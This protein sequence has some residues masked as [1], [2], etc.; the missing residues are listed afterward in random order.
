[1]RK[2]EV[3]AL[4]TALVLVVVSGGAHA[5]VRSGMY[6]ASTPAGPNWP[7]LEKPAWE[8]QNRNGIE[9]FR[10]GEL[11]GPTG[12]QRLSWRVIL[13]GEP[14]D[15][16]A[17]VRIP[18]SADN[19]VTSLLWEGCMVTFTKL[20]YSPADRYPQFYIRMAAGTLRI[21]YNNDTTGGG[22]RGWY[23]Y[24]SPS[25]G[26]RTGGGVIL[27]GTTYG[28]PVDH[29][30][31]HTLR[32]TTYTDGTW[33]VWLND[34]S[35]AANELWG[36][37][38]PVQSTKMIRWGVPDG[39]NRTVRFV[40]RA[41]YWGQGE[42]E[43]DPIPGPSETY[44]IGGVSVSASG[45]SATVTWTTEPGKNMVVNKVYYGDKFHTI[46]KA[47]DAV[48][49]TDHWEAQLNDLDWN[50]AYTFYC[51]ST[52]DTG[53][54][55][56]TPLHTFR[57]DSIVL[58][59]IANPG[60]EAGTDIY[61]WV[62]VFAPGPGEDDTQR[63][64]RV[65][66]DID[67]IMAGSNPGALLPAS[68]NPNIGEPA[69]FSGFKTGGSPFR[70]YGTI[71]Q[72][73]AVDVDKW[74]K[75]QVK[76]Q[77]WGN[78][79]YKPNDMIGRVGLD[80]NGDD[81]PGTL[82]GGV[83]TS[84][85]DVWWGQ[86]GAVAFSGQYKTASAMCQ[87]TSA[88]MSVFL[89]TE[90]N[91]ANSGVRVAFDDATFQEVAAPQPSTCGGAKQ[92]T[93]INDVAILPGVVV[94]ARRVMWSSPNLDVIGNVE[95]ADRAAGIRVVGTMADWDAGL[96]VGSEVDVMGPVTLNADGELEIRIRSITAVADPSGAVVGPVG[97]T[98]KSLGGGSFGMQAGVEGGTGMNNIG[99]LVTVCGKV[100][101]VGPLDGNGDYGVFIDDGSNLVGGETGSTTTHA[102]IEVVIP[103]E[104]GIATWSFVPGRTYVA[105][106]G[107]SSTKLWDPDV[108]PMPWNSVQ[109]RAVR[110]RFD[111][112]VVYVIP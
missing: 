102:G 43:I 63:W 18:L 49:N 7:L 64:G 58:P 82:L 12:D 60:F 16:K 59:N 14:S 40:T 55:Y 76:F 1:M 71:R 31:W 6:D 87:A 35:G 34:Q 17:D 104:T 98:N 74:Y 112:D 25:N 106:T 38:G 77:G 19:K 86:A 105:V 79:P 110:A 54:E 111:S 70:E 50:T 39:T 108:F 10:S 61:P 45:N 52:D 28:L 27:F 65:Y 107:A 41:F 103:F 11:N 29:G 84:D 13:G 51:E 109:K 36:T 3:C 8:V 91:L 75:A 30:I 57:T 94:T 37:L 85:P 46:N 21:G 83:F 90:F 33:H 26:T 97:V 80:P 4:A 24:G 15:A 89:Q 56:D 92:V 48:W 20:G 68:P 9:E 23:C 93:D 78:I 2:K 42:G 101:A 100:T 47:A 69:A 81:A 5:W 95:D 96:D 73:V 99:L 53:Q 72:K 22:T 44:D 66:S 67:M 88:E 32:V 62:D